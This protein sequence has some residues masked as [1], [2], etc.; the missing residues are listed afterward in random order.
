MRKTISKP[1]Q[2][3]IFKR[4][5]WCCR[6]CGI[7]VLLSPALK[8]LNEKYPGHGY[9]HRNGKKSKMAKLFLDKCACVDH[10]IPVAKGGLNEIENMVCAC[11]E[12]NT[13]KSDDSDPKWI[14]KMIKI[15]ELQ[16]SDG[17]D[18]LFSI[19]KELEPSNEWVSLIEE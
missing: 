10:I 8:A 12:C 17:W 18:G 9:Y 19:L 13:K 15:D 6:Y 1:E 7:E 16:P 14:K 5:Q 4:D 11:W 2:T 3:K